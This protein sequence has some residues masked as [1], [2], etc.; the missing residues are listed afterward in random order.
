MIVSFF[1]S[2][3]KTHKVPQLFH[4]SMSECGKE[5]GCSRTRALFSLTKCTSNF[6]ENKA[7]HATRRVKKWEVKR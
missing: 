7:V 6:S 2:G 1:I 4:S 5:T 3:I